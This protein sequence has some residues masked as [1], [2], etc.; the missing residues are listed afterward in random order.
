MR[1]ADG[2]LHKID[3]LFNDSHQ[4]AENKDKSL[5]FVVENGDREYFFN[6][7]DAEVLD[8]HIMDK[9]IRAICIDP[10]RTQSLYHRLISRQTPRNLKPTE[11]VKMIPYWNFS[12]INSNRFIWKYLNRTIYRSPAFEGADA[13]F[14]WH[15]RNKRVL[16]EEE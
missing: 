13:Q 2:V 1:T 11:M 6:S 10:K 8:Y 15:L 4:L 9:I 12:S 7:K 5:I 16:N 3:I 14:L